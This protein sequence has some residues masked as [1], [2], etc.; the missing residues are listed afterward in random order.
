MARTMK[1]AL[2]LAIACAASPALAQE[3]PPPS[4]QQAQEAMQ[5]GGMTDERSLADET[6]RGHF[7]LA[8]SLYDQGQ[9]A[10]AAQEFEEAYRLSQ[11]PELM[12]NA[13][14]AY[15]DANDI[16]SAARCLRVYLENAG[17]RVQDRV[18][19]EARLRTMEQAVAEERAREEALAAEQRA[20]E[21]ERQTPPRGPET[22]PWIVLGVGAAV[23][24][25]G[26]ITGGIALGE[27]DRLAA[28]CPGTVCGPEIDFDGRNANIDTLG[29]AADVLLFGG[30]AIAVTGLILGLAL[31]IGESAPESQPEVSAACGPAGCAASLRTRF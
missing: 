16:A 19:L 31:G 25:A 8:T 17:D 30:A 20:R 18:N 12:F 9:F 4:G 29:I 23:V 6:A 22:W 24:I 13:Y 28:D 2:A 7:Q 10:Q 26:A 11:R 21:R 3:G 27:A 14:V 1:G 5:G 15:R